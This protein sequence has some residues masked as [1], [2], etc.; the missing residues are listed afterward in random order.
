M[1]FQNPRAIG[2]GYRKDPHLFVGFSGLQRRAR[3]ARKF[4]TAGL[5]NVGMCFSGRGGVGWARARKGGRAR[6]RKFQVESDIDVRPAQRKTP[7]S[8]SKTPGSF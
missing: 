7:E 2:A 1:Q 4:P 6:A 3:G 5:K 8:I